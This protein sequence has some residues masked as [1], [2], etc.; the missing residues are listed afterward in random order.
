[1]IAALA[2]FLMGFIS[3]M[4]VV[5]PISLLVFQRGLL[6]RYQDGWMIGLG[7]ALAEG[8]YCALAVHGFS[9]L[10]EG[11]TFLE[12]LARGVGILLLLTLGLY[13][14]LV[15]QENHG[16]SPMAA[17]SSSNW[18]GRFLVGLSVAALNPTPIMTWSA[19]V[20]ML[21]STADASHSRCSKG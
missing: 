19:S 3:S 16:K 14:K 1:M 7:G 13:F 20:A 10:R 9:A 4:P 5:G 21:H 8:I 17:P 6:A 18:A 2:G 12:P 15:R 11:F